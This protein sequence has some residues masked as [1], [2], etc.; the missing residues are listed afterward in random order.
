MRKLEMCRLSQELVHSRRK[1]GNFWVEEYVL[2]VEVRQA[3]GM[4]E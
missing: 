2:T 4:L 1:W 3:L